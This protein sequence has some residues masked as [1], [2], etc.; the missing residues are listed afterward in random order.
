MY[1]YLTKKFSDKEICFKNN[2][3]VTWAKYVIP[4]PIMVACS[5]NHAILPAFVIWFAIAPIVIISLRRAVI[6]PI[7]FV[8]SFPI[9]PNPP[10][11]VVDRIPQQVIYKS[12]FILWFNHGKVCSQILTRFPGIV[13]YWCI[14]CIS[15]VIARSSM[16]HE[17]CWTS[18]CSKVRQ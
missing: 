12:V 11:A 15:N 10:I 2:G 16:Y 6:K 9:Q 8:I 5:K 17:A 1:L 4:C 3:T 13:P 18:I 7:K 14:R